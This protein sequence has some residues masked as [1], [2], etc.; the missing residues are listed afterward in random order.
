MTILPLSIGAAFNRPVRPQLPSAGRRH[1]PHRFNEELPPGA[2]ASEDDEEGHGF[3]LAP[4]AFIQLSI[5][6]FDF[7]NRR[8]R[9]VPF[10]AKG[11]SRRSCDFSRN[12]LF[13]SSAETIELVF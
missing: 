2:D 7:E 11:P 1:L 13:D 9:P 3:F 4:S 8:A 12:V 6:I 5:E 10:S